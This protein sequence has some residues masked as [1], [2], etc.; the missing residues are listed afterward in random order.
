VLEASGSVPG[1]SLVQTGA[2]RRHLIDCFVSVAQLEHSTPAHR[3]G[4]PSPPTQSRS[5]DL[6]AVSLSFGARAY[7]R[8]ANPNSVVFGSDAPSPVSFILSKPA[9]TLSIPEGGSPRV[10]AA[11]PARTAIWRHRRACSA[12]THFTNS[13]FV[14]TL[15]TTITTALH[16]QVAHMSPNA[17]VFAACARHATDERTV[18]LGLSI[19]VQSLERVFTSFL[20]ARPAM[21]FRR[22]T[23]WSASSSQT[24][25]RQVAEPRWRFGHRGMAESHFVTRTLSRDPRNHVRPGFGNVT[26]YSLGAERQ[27]GPAVVSLSTS[28]LPIGQPFDA[29]CFYGQPGRISRCRTWNIAAQA[30]IFSSG[31]GFFFFFFRAPNIFGDP[32]THTLTIARSGSKRSAAPWS[33]AS[34][35]SRGSAT[36][37]N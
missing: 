2:A 12:S 20:P 5:V 16:I 6:A 9:S 14:A 4:I 18:P 10:E 19:A 22:S 8:S 29:H 35:Y 23:R 26:D 21:L 7:R 11:N 31:D 1:V 25:H 36:H 34:A 27:L 24:N 17:D 37:T 32:T 30:S 13:G 33:T 15:R 28:A 3:R